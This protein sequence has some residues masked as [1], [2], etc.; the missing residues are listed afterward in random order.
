MVFKPERFLSLDGHTPERNPESIAFG[1]GRRIC[2][3]RVFAY[4]AIYIAIAQFLAVFDIS[5]P[6]ENGQEV[7]PVVDFEPGLVSHPVP[8]KAHVRPRSAKH[9][10]LIRAVEK[11]HPTPRESHASIYE[12][13]MQNS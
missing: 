10:A 6:V 3:G 13:L 12:S 5:K 8:F 9:E 2:P 1:F 4:H 7:D 11:E